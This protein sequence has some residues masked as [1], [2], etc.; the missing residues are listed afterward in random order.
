[1]PG[2]LDVAG[3]LRGERIFVTGATGFVG[4]AL[5]E[6]LLWAVPDVGRILLL[7][8]PGGGR[9]A[10]ER[11]RDEVLSSPAMARLRARHGPD[12]PAW[13]A[14]KVEAVAG[15]LGEDRFGLEP[16]AWARLCG[17]V[18]RVVASAATVA[19][20]ERLDRAVELNARGA[21]RTLELAH[22]A[23]D[24]PLVHLSTCFVGG[25]RR[26]WVPEEPARL[27]G[28]AG[29]EPDLDAVL[30]ELD[31]ACRG[32]RTNG[33]AE[34]VAAGAA[35]ARRLGFPD[36]YTLTK[37]L[38][39]RLVARDR[40]RVPVA[41]VRPAIVESA[42]AEPVPGWIEA[43]RVVDPLLVAY[44]R[45]RTRVLPGTPDLPL[46]LVPVDFVASAVLAALADL[47][48]REGG[49]AGGRATGGGPAGE[50]DLRGAAAA[51]DEGRSGAPG[52][53]AAADQGAAELR[54]Y[55]V[56]SS[57]HP[58]TLGEVVAH[59]REGLRRS[60]LRDGQDEPIEVPEAR[61]V[62]PD[63]L[64]RRLRA[65]RRRLGT[66]A[67]AMS[68]LGRRR[69]AE[70]LAVADR[71][72]EH[73]ARL[74]EVYRP[75]LVPGARYRDDAT[76]ALSD[77][78]APAARA[79]FPF[80]VAAIDWRRYLAVVHVPGLVRFALRAESG[81]P[82]PER[83]V[84]HLAER[85]AEARG[86]AG[87][88][89]TLFD[90]FA[91]VARA[92]PDR[93]ALQTHR[94]RR[95]LRY[96]Y[97]QALTATANVAWRLAG[98]HGVGR[99]DRVV[100]WASGSPEW[101]ITT[102]AVHRLGAA[103]VP[104]DPQWPAAEIAEAARLVEAKLVCAD[105]RLPH[106]RREE[107]AAALGGPDAAGPPSPTGPPSRP[108]GRPVVE[109]G[110]ALVPEPGV[111]L[112]PGAEAI[113]EAD[114]GGPDD[115]ASILFTSGTTVAPKAVPLTHANYLANVRDLVPVMRW[116]RER[117]L[118]VL[119]VHHAFEQTVG[120]LVPLAGAGTVTY[121]AEM[122]P[123]EIRWAMATTRPTAMV[124]VPRLLE[125]LHAGIFQSVEA[126]GPALRGL[127]KVLFAL[128]RAT[129]GRF[130]HRLF[131]KVHRRFGGA[132]RRIATGGSAL[133]PA[134]GRS[135]ALMGFLVAEGYGMTETAPVLAVN[136]WR[137]IRFGSV[138]RPLP[139]VEVELRPPDGDVGAE[140]GVGEI[141]VR[142]ANV[143][144][145]YHRNPEATA[146]A[147]DGDGWL[148][149]GDLGRFDADGYLWLAGRT[150][151]VIVTDAG[152]NVYPEEVEQ[153]YRG[154]P[155]VQELVVLGLPAGDGGR[156]ERVA[157]VVVPSPGAGDDGEAVDERIR[158]EIAAR[159]AEVPSYQQVSRAVVWRGELPKTTTLKVKRGRLREAVLAGERSD[160]ASRPA[161]APPAAAA[162][163]S[164]PSEAEAW[165]VSTLARLTRARPDR[166]RP[167]DRLAEIGVDSLTRVELVG[168]LEARTGRRLD[169]AAVATLA[170]VQDVVELAR[171]SETTG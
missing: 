45:G 21:R 109:L 47:P 148:D 133:E 42:L 170:S 17:R 64:A 37:A 101:A 75:Y 38:G 118:S 39:E 157:A 53:A 62:D 14:G 122:R 112:L 36:V 95:W 83:E 11:L 102:F 90:L 4:K 13:A 85:L 169:D 61:F 114:A 165:A 135:F 27:G 56:G 31:A 70:R 164:P 154:L 119:P 100:L 66:L 9:S 20:D 43:V 104:L 81:A 40:G 124:A 24:A 35:E 23:G 41:V 22:A 128:S 73:F 160:G 171:R 86:H 105:P 139:G 88:A 136:P 84:P 130:G 113:G 92:H 106:G 33:G 50:S 30:A 68:S 28:E 117:L 151:D 162:A 79:A 115:L 54:I 67:G 116:T 158:A 103:I 140:E 156:G 132:L 167:D 46:E 63:R 3:A 5:V 97:D 143:M 129:G 147:I 99:G 58:V 134:L 71:T 150:K 77:R 65:R 2:E 59:A 149:T 57:R 159:S 161:P 32:A 96:T 19:F 78:L 8:R 51:R 146:E 120:L 72:L 142:G 144:A 155:G 138:G 110:P 111:A 44:G 121:L 153:R 7:V 34:L 89:G 131:G 125:L 87:R 163:E 25:G 137:A 1:M 127:F 168:A 98:R 123:A 108:D 10:Q 107:L 18:D 166:I 52:G 55:Q 80:D 126:G 12:W 93:I 82:P 74:I 16:D 76:L 94:D 29:D 91:S 6:K 69:P 48:R 49:G 152:K 141:W 60:P 145:G 15:D 26:G